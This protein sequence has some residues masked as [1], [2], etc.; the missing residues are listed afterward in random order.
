MD[1]QLVT[2]LQWI[3]VSQSGCVPKGWQAGLLTVPS[4]Y[5]QQGRLQGRPSG[6]F[7]RCSGRALRL[8]TTASRAAAAA[9]LAAEWP[10]A[11]RRRG[12]LLPAVMPTEGETVATPLTA[13]AE[14]VAVVAPMRLRLNRRCRG[15]RCFRRRRHLRY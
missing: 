6:R 9:P 14:D 12:P 13:S 11:A 5:R 7:H 3:Q 1:D 10:L 2:Q 8:R 15:H 4:S